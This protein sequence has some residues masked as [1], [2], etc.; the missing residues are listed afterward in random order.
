MYITCFSDSGVLPEMPLLFLGRCFFS[1][2][3]AAFGTLYFCGTL[4]VKMFK[5]RFLEIKSWELLATCVGHVLGTWLCAPTLLAA[6]CVC[7]EDVS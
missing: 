6:P 4:A 3:V 1:T 2:C 5:I 7:G